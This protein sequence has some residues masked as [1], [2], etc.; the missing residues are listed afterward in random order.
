LDRFDKPHFAK[1]LGKHAAKFELAGRTGISRRVLVGLRVYAD[2]PA[3]AFKQRVHEA[4][5]S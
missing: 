5:V 4:K 2:I 1:F 3:K